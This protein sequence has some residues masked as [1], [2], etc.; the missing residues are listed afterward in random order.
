MSQVNIQTDRNNSG[1]IKDSIALGKLSIRANISVT[2][3][4]NK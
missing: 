3:E 1:E 4:L 2:F